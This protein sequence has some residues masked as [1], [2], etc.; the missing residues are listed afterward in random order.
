[1]PEFRYQHGDRPLEGYTIQH[2]VGRGGFGEVYYALSDSGRQ[3]ALKAVQNDQVV[4]LRGI[5]HCMNLKS[6]HLVAIFDV[7]YGDGGAPFVLMEYVAGPSLRRLLDESPGGLGPARSAFFLREIGKGLTYLHDCGIVH[8]DL[9]PHNV[10]YE[11]GYVK[12]GDYSLSK[13]MSAS[14]HS[15]HTMTVGT[16]H[17]MAPEISRGRYDRSVDIYAMGVILY[18]MLTGRPPHVGETPGEILM[19]HL[20]GEPDVSGVPEP[21]ASVVRK[22]MATDPADRYATVQEMVDAVFGA[23]QPGDAAGELRPESLSM[24]ADRVG[25]AIAAPAGPAPAGA[26]SGP[27]PAPGRE[28][29]GREADGDRASGVAAEAPAEHERGPAH[30]R[31]IQ[32]ALLTLAVMSIGVALLASAAPLG[33]HRVFLGAFTFV[34]MAG[35][36]AGVTTARRYLVPDV[37]NNRNGG[38][39][40]RLAAGGLGALGACVP[41]ILLVVVGVGGGAMFRG[42]MAA[43]A[44]FL[45]VPDWSAATR[46]DRRET[47]SLGRALFLG[48]GGMLVAWMLGG[49]GPV[50]FGILA[51]TWLAV[52]V[53]SPVRRDKHDKRHGVPVDG[54]PPRPAVPPPPVAANAPRPPRP[55]SPQPAAL[56]DGVSPHRR[57]VALVLSLVPLL[58]TPLAGLHRLYVGKIGTGILWLLTGG[59]FGVGQLIDIILIALGRSTDKAGRRLVIWTSAD[60]LKWAVPAAKPVRASARAVAVPPVPRQ[61]GA[62]STLTLC[63]AAA[64]LLALL[65][66][67]GMAIDLPR[68]VQAGL[69][70][71]AFTGGDAN[72]LFGYTQWQA[73]VHRAGALV[74]GVLMLVSVVLLVG[75]R[76]GAGLAHMARVVVA[77]FGFLLAFGA[78]KEA[79]DAIPWMVVAAEVARHNAPAGIDVLLRGFDVQ[80]LLVAALLYLASFFLLAWPPAHR[81][82][83][84]SGRAA[85]VV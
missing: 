32:L 54:P 58:G 26:P 74:L 6:P 70:A 24:A 17:Y 1:M 75:A 56:P 48:L 7:R 3:V 5:A 57:L 22:A 18:E 44:V 23:A 78:L 47:I 40:A 25:A 15:G 66:S 85:E 34:V 64:L 27:P 77:A 55:P 30:G 11:D 4:E 29:G 42:T 52:Q 53:L 33:G 68:A 67:F 82:A 81:P 12:I 36:T 13:A 46:R 83:L 41:A 9:K 19:K 28:T 60:E 73:L 49:S 21:F 62:A 80:S 35:A 39:A 43:V 38:S 16:V 37:R 84:M 59:L 8:R 14:Q 10:F 2:G 61:T 79:C 69:F 20:T 50:A 51:G 72:V 45:F 71:P 63:G 76:R 65:L 31:R